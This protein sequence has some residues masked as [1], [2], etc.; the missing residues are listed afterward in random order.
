MAV[1]E[2]AFP[3]P[4]PNLLLPCQHQDPQS[5]PALLLVSGSPAETQQLWG[6]QQEADGV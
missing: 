1:W 5:S 3:S 6:A 4:V 2:G